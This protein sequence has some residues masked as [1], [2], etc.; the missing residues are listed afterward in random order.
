M[1]PIVGDLAGNRAKIRHHYA[2]AEAAGCDIVGVPGTR[3]HRLPAEDLVLKPG[4]VADN[5][6]VLA[7]L[8][9][10]TGRCAAVIGFVDADR[11]IYNAAAV[12]RK[13]VSS[14]PT[15]SV[16]SQLRGVRRGALLHARSRERSAGALR[17]RWGEGRRVHLRGH[18]EPERPARRAG[19]RRRGV[20]RQHQRVPVPP[21]QG[22]RPGAHARHPGRRRQL[23]TRVREPGARSG[24]TRL[25]RRV[26]GVRR[27]RPTARPGPPVPGGTAD[28]R[29]RD[30]ARLPQAPPRP[31][32]PRHRH[33]AARRPRD[34]RGGVGRRSWRHGR[35]ERDRPAAGPGRRDVRRAGARG[36]ATTCS[37]TASPTW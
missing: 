32:R 11:D 17:D 20:E 4:F 28:R 13:G 26:D 10:L 18:L 19:R 3:R 7:E 12:A 14:A 15:A 31:P 16:C 2:E 21:R 5:I 37:T 34:H 6:D 23:R 1:D 9:A 22:A 30:P 27:G 29:G 8:A 33:R 24:R 36:R 25:R 35:R